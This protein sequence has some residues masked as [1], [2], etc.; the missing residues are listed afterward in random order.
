MLT[1]QFCDPPDGKESGLSAW[2]TRKCL[3]GTDVAKGADR[4]LPRCLGGVRHLMQ[5]KLKYVPLY[6]T[7]NFQTS[8]IHPLIHVFGGTHLLYLC[9]GGSNTTLSQNRVHRPAYLR[10]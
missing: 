2:H 1:P 9:E 3:I 5:E 6:I 8:K 10:L 7:G 4:R